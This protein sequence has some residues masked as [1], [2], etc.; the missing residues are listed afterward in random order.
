M[1]LI[2]LAFT[3]LTAAAV[4]TFVITKPPFMDRFHSERSA[5]AFSAASIESAR[6]QLPVLAP[7]QSN[8]SAQE[9]AQVG[10]TKPAPPPQN[11]TTVVDE[12]AL[13]YFASK[14]DRARLEAEIARLRTLYP[15][16][17]PP[18]DPL[19]IPQNSDHLLEQMWQLYS[20][21]RYADVRKAIADRQA[22][23]PTWTPP[24]DLLARLEI[25]EARARLVTA[26]DAKNYAEVIEIGAGTP[27]LL[28]CS[29]VD[30]LWRV[31]EAF[32]ETDR[33]R[34]SVDAYSYI[35]KNCP[36][37]AERI[38]TIQKAAALLDYQNVEELLGFER[39]AADGTMEF[40]VIRDDL[41]RRFVA[42]GDE[43]PELA[44][45]PAYLQRLN[46]LAEREK[47]SSDALLLGW[48]H[49]RRDKMADAERW[50]RKARGIEDTASASQGLAL[51]LIARKNPREAEET[52]YRWRD[53]SAEMM[54]TY[55]A[56]TANLLA[57]DPP[58]MLDPK[59]LQRIATVTVEEKNVTTA[60]QFGW[61]AI[62]MRQP[63]TAAQWF[64]MG[65][66]WKDDDEPSAYGLAVARL[67]LNDRAG[68]RALQEAWRG[69]S[70]RITRIGESKRTG[71][72]DEAPVSTP[73][74]AARRNPR[75]PGEGRLVPIMSKDMAAAPSRGEASQVR[76][77]GCI[78][79]LNPESLAPAGALTRGWC[80]MERNRPLE[81]IKAFEVALRSTSSATQQDA[82]Y[83]QSLAYLRAGLVNQAAVS[84]TKTPQDWQRAREL[85]SA[86]LSA[87]A[88]AAFNSGRYHE[89]LLLLD[90]LAQFRTE[91]TDLMV[92]R[93]HT[94]VRLKRGLDA[95]RVFEAVAETGNRD[96]IRA[97]ADL[98]RTESTL[99]Q[100]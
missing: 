8:A 38:A 80:L 41:T 10:Q 6:G 16:W 29:D 57:L 18:R 79:T 55:L 5:V 61:Y 65:L 95:R 70:E 27:S 93:G 77:A 92:L 14:G 83:G 89:T 63:K 23:D 25:A 51:T 75:A 21:S 78:S 48:Y 32:A 40:E 100:R 91:R 19:A 60:Q 9:V 46:R 90:Q 81:A 28:T 31:A 84:A 35:L 43:D 76:Q 71:E 50:F 39:K 37:E 47:L 69:R 45:A 4:G 15:N 74:E 88:I 59:V 1:K 34:R 98:R 62:A 20:Q 13:R 64:A 11:A 24:A 42:E 96:A 85:Q 72:A 33:P 3:C 30:V 36:D 52:V 86:I 58:V 53:S 67:Q 97:L 44:I 87:R 49:L 68:V 54:A 56:A 66:D 12:S 2:V 99:I 73:A 7:K 17:V 94:Y 22:S 26:S 82:A